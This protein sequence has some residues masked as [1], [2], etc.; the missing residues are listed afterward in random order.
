MLQGITVAEPPAKR[1]RIS[2]ASAAQLITEQPTQ[3]NS[4]ARASVRQLPGAKE[5]ALLVK[6]LLAMAKQT[7]PAGME[8]MKPPIRSL[9]M[10]M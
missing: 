4:A 1:R 5:R 3:L 6:E 2:N 7:G 9:T 10:A 8:I